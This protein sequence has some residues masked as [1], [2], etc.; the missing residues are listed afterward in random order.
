MDNIKIDSFKLRILKSDLSDT[1]LPSNFNRDI[2]SIYTDTAELVNPN[3]VQIKTKSN[4][5]KLTN[6]N[7]I[8]SITIG[9]EKY[10]VSKLHSRVSK[11][12]SSEFVTLKITSKLL[13]QSY[14]DGIN[15]D[16]LKIILEYLRSVKI[17]IDMT[18]L[19]SSEIT[20]IDF[21]RDILIP[22][23]DYKE[24]IDTI[25]T[26]AKPS[27]LQSKG[28][29]QFRDADNKGI[30]FSNR[31]KATPA[32]P[33]FKIYNKYLDAYSDEHSEFFS[34]YG[35]ETAPD[36][37]RIEFTLKDKKHFAKYNLSNTLENFISLT[38]LELENILQSIT[39]YHI[40]KTKGVDVILREKQN[41][42]EL[43]I[44]LSIKYG[45][46]LNL[47]YDNIKKTYL[48]GIENRITKY[49]YS[50]LMDRIFYELNSTSNEIKK[51]DRINNLMSKL[52]LT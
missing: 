3:E 25:K 47:P 4:T 13:K 20:D 51:R 37:H 19:L 45:L 40:I 27:K 36:L 12:H 42:N 33:F 35:L 2:T 5:L 23:I 9:L 6:D 8:T 14:Y 31:K 48:A 11:L 30:E 44:E 32:N 41:V 52:C 49:R 50:K 22:E 29:N 21:C 10:R 7:G 39:D 46:L 34:Y 26:V 43:G 15:K 1:D 16:T 18:K 38:Q 28:Y 17:N 24:L